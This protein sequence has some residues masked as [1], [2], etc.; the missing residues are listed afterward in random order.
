MVTSYE[1]YKQVHKEIKS[2][3]AKA[4][5]VLFTTILRA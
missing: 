4:L 5:P 2:V 3:K 1:E